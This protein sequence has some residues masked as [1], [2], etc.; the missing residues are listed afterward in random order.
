MANHTKPTKAELEANAIKAA[1]EAEA[2]LKNPP[3]PEP[4]PTPSKPP[5]PEPSKPDYENKFKESSKEGQIL[6]ARG[7]AV[8]E[9]IVKAGNL[10]EPTEDELKAE[11][12]DW[13]V[14]TDFERKMA[15][16]AFVNTRYRNYINEAT[17][18]FVD[19]DKWNEE[20][21][22]FVDNPVNIKANPDLAGKEAKFKEFAGRV[23]YRGTP[24]EVL[25]GAFLHDVSTKKVEHKGQMFPTGTGGPNDKPTP[26]S[27][28]ITLEQAKIIRETDYKKYVQ[29]TKEGKIETNL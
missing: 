24:M 29:L 13:D 12:K 25:V 27:D 11:N 22:A 10:P 2:L 7:K 8:N 18:Q 3:A 28:K 17:K 5:A 6:Y 9:A 16:D 19:M 21:E 1:E 4:E 14:M 20:I 15:K 26:V 23:Q